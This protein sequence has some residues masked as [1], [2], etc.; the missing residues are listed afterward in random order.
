MQLTQD[1]PAVGDVQDRLVPGPNGQIRVRIYTPADAPAG[2]LRGLVYF[3]GGGLVAGGLDTHDAICRI[4]CNETGSRLIAV[5]YRLAPEHPFPAAVTD[6]Y[7]ATKWVIANAKML[8]IAPG[9]VAVG[10]DFAG[11]TLAAVVSQMVCR[12]LG[13]SLAWQL[14]L[15]P[16]MD[17]TAQTVS[18]LTCAPN[19]L[20][21][22]AMMDHDLSFYLPL[23]VA[24]ADPRVSPLQADDLHGLPPAFIHTA[25]FDPLRDEGKMY[26]DRLAAAGVAV[27][28]TCHA[29]MVHLFYALGRAVP[30]ASTALGQIGRDI[31]RHFERA[32]ETH[33]R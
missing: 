20:I 19:N 30:Y 23:G 15:C 26:A 33:Y 25:E 24:P 17:Y 12:L 10:G 31:R 11:A 13:E 9:E 1:A 16:I 29:G 4:L 5:D 21:N 2:L 3:H 14:L 18:R 22:Q 28:Y 8:R 32:D 7:A 6:S 27:R